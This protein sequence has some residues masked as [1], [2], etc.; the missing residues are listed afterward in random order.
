MATREELE[1]LSSEELHD[2]ATSHAKRHANVK[3]FWQLMRALPAAEAA[4]GDVGEA[5]DDVQSLYGHLDDLKRSGQGE[6]AD[7]LRPLY[8]DYLLKHT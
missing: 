4:A 6:V 1:A 3:F 8:I 7:L 2:R 5:D